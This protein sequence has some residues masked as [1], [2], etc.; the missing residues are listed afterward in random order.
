M[1]RKIVR[2][3]SA[4]IRVLQSMRTVEGFS[5]DIRAHIDVNSRVSP[6]CRMS[7]GSSLIN[8]SVGRFTYLADKAAVKHAVIGQFCSIAP[9]VYIG[10]GIHPTHW[11]STNPLFYSTKGQLDVSFSDVDLFNETKRI[12]IGDDVWVGINAVILDGVTIG[13]GAVVAAGAIVTK[14]VPPY[15]IVGGVPAKIIKFRFDQE[16]IEA[17]LQ[18]NWWDFS[19]E[20]IKSASNC[21]VGKDKWTINDVS[22]LKKMLSDD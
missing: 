16:V 14:D 15:A 22:H 8:S 7:K 2:K 18:L 3:L 10:V 21:F 11:I 19:I 20:S 9:N 1:I 17:L 12:A 4:I 13:S 5:A 6:Y